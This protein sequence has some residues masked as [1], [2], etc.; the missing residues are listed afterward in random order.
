MASTI[1][2][3]LVSYWKLD[4]S[5]GN[6][7]DSSG[8]GFTL[9]KQGTTTYSS[10][11]INNGGN[12]GSSDANANGFSRADGMSVDLSGAS[13]VS[14][15]LKFLGAPTVSSRI[16]TWGSVTGTSRY[17]QLNYTNA[18]TSLQVNA[19]SNTSSGTVNLNDGSFHHIA[20]TCSGSGSV[21]L[22]HNGSAIA[23][24]TRGTD[25]ASAQFA[26]GNISSFL[27]GLPAIFDEMGTWSKELTSGEVNQLYSGGAG[28]SYPFNISAYGGAQ[29]LMMM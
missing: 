11:L 21:S 18:T 22:Y 14:L 8:N 2:T 28:L 10:A 24:T 9:T 1:L 17:F 27:V 20:Y 29:L 12:L 13:S 15:W 19:A 16:M 4:E 25:T 7:A 6:A 5:S 26:I 3:G 23:S